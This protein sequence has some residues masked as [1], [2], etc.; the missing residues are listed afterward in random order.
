M[1]QQ[2]TLTAELAA[3]QDRFSDY[4][5]EPVPAD[6][7][8]G[9]YATISVFVTWVVTTTPFLVTAALS[10][11]LTFWEAVLALLVGTV[12]T[13][14]VGALVANVG[15]TTGL[16]S[17]F[18]S[19]TVYGALGSTVVSVLVGTLAVG[20]LGVLASFLGAIFNS[21]VSFVPAQVASIAFILISVFIALVGFTGLST[22]GRM[23]APLIWLVGLFILWRVGIAAGGLAKVTSVVPKGTLSFGLAVTFVVADWITGATICCDIARYSQK[24]SY[25]IGASYLSWVVTYFLLALVG[26]VAYYGT[27]T[28]DVIA[29]IKS[30]GLVVAFLFVFILGIIS[31][32]DVNLYAFSLALTNFSDAFG[33]KP[34]KRPLWVVVGGILSALISLLG[35]ANT[36]LPFLLTIGTIIPAYAGV[37]LAH[38]YLLGALRRN[39]RELVAGIDPGFRWTAIVALL[40]G[41]AVA[42]FFKSGIPALQGL[43]TSAVVYAVLEWVVARRT[44]Q[45]S[46]GI[47][48]S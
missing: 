24:R 47:I 5:L 33:L 10:A 32:T 30:L 41:I 27:G 2:E 40:V 4:A 17:Y 35:Y 34:L 6:R 45:H 14:T 9:P 25:V 38:Y 48:N 19:R 3:I 13:A 18:V 15:Q 7:R 16:T 11:G 42:Y 44:A 12:I 8:R 29:L 20:F 43:F 23:A 22:L 46:A 39:S 36:F 21:D 37:V 1:S 26:L 31:A 28:H